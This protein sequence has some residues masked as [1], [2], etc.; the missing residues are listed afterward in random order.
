MGETRYVRT[1][2]D[3]VL[4][5]EYLVDTWLT[6]VIGKLSIE[7]LLAISASRPDITYPAIHDATKSNLCYLKPGDRLTFQFR[8]KLVSWLSTGQA[9]NSGTR[10]LPTGDHLL[11]SL[12]Q[13]YFIKCY[14]YMSISRQFMC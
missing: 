1:F 2:I 14:T 7:S 3:S 8:G 5:D 6:P 9:Q 12:S 10:M 4:P 11:R 13:G